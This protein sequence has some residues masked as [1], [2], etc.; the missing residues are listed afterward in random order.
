MVNLINVITHEKNIMPGAVFN[1]GSAGSLVKIAEGIRRRGMEANSKLRSLRE[2]KDITL[3]SWKLFHE[4][5]NSSWPHNPQK[6]E[7]YNHLIQWAAACR[8]RAAASASIMQSRTAKRSWAEAKNA[9]YSFSTRWLPVAERKLAN[10]ALLSPEF[11]EL[12]MDL[13]PR[14]NDPD[15]YE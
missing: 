11:H 12:L 8:M 5:L 14:K 2:D 15:E 9:D 4:K 6:I 10:N 7:M 3:K 13:D 1:A